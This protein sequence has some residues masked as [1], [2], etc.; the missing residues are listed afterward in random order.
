MK[1][2]PGG[3]LVNWR[4]LL[5][6]SLH[7]LI[8]FILC[9]PLLR[10]HGARLAVAV[11][12]LVVACGLSGVLIW[13]SPGI[14]RSSMLAL[15]AQLA[16]L[17]AFRL[18]MKSDFGRSVFV[19][20]QGFVMTVIIQAVLSLLVTILGF[21]AKD[22]PIEELLIAMFPAEFVLVLLFVTLFPRKL[23]RELQQRLGKSDIVPFI[24]FHLSFLMFFFH[25]MAGAD[26]RTI[27]EMML[28]MLIFC[29]LAMLL[30]SESIKRRLVIEELS[31][32]R[33]SATS[34]A[35]ILQDIRS[36][37]HDYRNHIQVLKL[38][39]ELGKSPDGALRSRLEELSK[40][41]RRND[42]FLSIQSPALAAL[43][44]LKQIEAEAAGVDFSLDHRLGDEAL[45]DV[46]DF[47]LV[48]ALGNL[49]DNA[50]RAAAEC[51]GA[52]IVR[53]E[54]WR[55]GEQGEI[56]ARVMNSS[57]KLP[58]DF[59]QTMYSTGMTT[60]RNDGGSHGYGL[61]NAKRLLEH[62]GGSMQLEAIDGTVSV[63]IELPA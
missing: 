23:F 46:N 31:S 32:Y 35:P 53:V 14:E 24:F 51:E 4:L 42:D 59:M 13:L 41:I 1:T 57:R 61:R 12:G 22:A 19:V 63:M 43:M 8:N 7:L 5:A 34:F 52:H 17:L 2:T 28:F 11:S 45:S 48:G 18:A 16:F 47:I 9:I 38:Q 50:I 3:N 15:V 10:F 54:L 6:G 44:Y 56:L 30:F 62:G 39:I 26:E 40:Q 58:A 37:Q 20:F 49:L 29:T 55:G 36:R 21:V 27:I 60:K 33:K 25:Q